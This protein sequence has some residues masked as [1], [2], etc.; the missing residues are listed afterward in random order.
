MLSIMVITEDMT[1][2]TRAASAPAM[3][4]ASYRRDFEGRK[5]V[6]PKLVVVVQPL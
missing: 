5:L 1:P 4:V 2:R 3:V 6:R